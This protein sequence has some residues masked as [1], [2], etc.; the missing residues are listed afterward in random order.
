MYATIESLKGKTEVDSDE[1]E[2]EQ[3]EQSQDARRTYMHTD[4]DAPVVG[5]NR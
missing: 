3:K 1:E 5:L 4:E 2:E